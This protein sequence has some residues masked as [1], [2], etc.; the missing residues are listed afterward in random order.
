[1]NVASLCMS[2]SSYDRYI[3]IYIYIYQGFE[4]DTCY[5]GIRLLE[6]IVTL[7]TG[8]AGRCYKS[9]LKATILRQRR[10]IMQSIYNVRG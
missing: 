8:A 2:L 3:Y 9:I 10:D 4:L 1:M 5:T 6:A 7:Q